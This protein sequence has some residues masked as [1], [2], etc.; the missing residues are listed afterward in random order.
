[1]TSF[2]PLFMIT[3]CCTYKPYEIQKYRCKQ[4]PGYNSPHEKTG[5]QIFVSNF[6][7]RWSKYRYISLGGGGLVAFEIVICAT[8]D[9]NIPL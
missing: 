6:D 4:E 1:M 9:S 5:T 8:M 3:V 2:H 7:A